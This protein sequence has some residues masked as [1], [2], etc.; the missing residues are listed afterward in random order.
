M[1]PLP[2]QI[3]SWQKLLESTILEHCS[4]PKHLQH[5]RLVT[6]SAFQCLTWQLSPPG[7]R[8]GSHGR[9]LLLSHSLLL[10]GWAIRTMSSKNLR[11]VFWSVQWVTEVP[12]WRLIIF[13][14]SLDWSIFSGSICHRNLRKKDIFKKIGL[15][16]SRKSLS[17]LWLWWCQRNTDFSDYTWQRI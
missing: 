15:R 9:G 11:C 3:L 13:S 1:F 6:V 5:P 7:L 16:H 17:G 4:I 12:A 8:A 14:T 2:R 10:P